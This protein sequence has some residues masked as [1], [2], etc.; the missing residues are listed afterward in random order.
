MEVKKIIPRVCV[1]GE[2]MGYRQKDYEDLLIQR[3]DDSRKPADIENELIREFGWN[4]ICCR[5]S[6]FVNARIPFI[7]DSNR[8][9]YVNMEKNGDHV[10]KDGLALV[11]RREPPSFPLLKDEV[12]KGKGTKKEDDEVI[13]EEEVIPLNIVKGKRNLVLKKK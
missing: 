10:Y 13:K 9:A 11:P 8:D 2:R 5:S 7:R 1:C 6:Y 3:K 12:K 4:K